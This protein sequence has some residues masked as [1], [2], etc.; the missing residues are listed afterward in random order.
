MTRRL[1]FPSGS[2]RAEPRPA[3][4]AQGRRPNFKFEDGGPT[5]SSRHP[6]VLV[7]VPPLN[8]PGVETKTWTPPAARLQDRKAVRH[9]DIED[10]DACGEVQRCDRRPET[11]HVESR[12]H[13]SRDHQQRGRSIALPAHESSWTAPSIA[14]ANGTPCPVTNP[15]MHIDVPRVETAFVVK[16]NQRQVSVR[17]RAG[18][19]SFDQRLGH[20]CRCVS[21]RMSTCAS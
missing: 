11:S 8:R 13:W 18:T 21:R 20:V 16:K 17:V 19:C 2:P 10:V 9:Y 5:L 7:P 12:P 15:C 14:Y 4:S 6:S 1:R 3:R